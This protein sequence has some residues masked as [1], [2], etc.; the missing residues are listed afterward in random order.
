MSTANR[1]E[2][3][4]GRIRGLVVVGMLIGAM[5][6]AGRQPIVERDDVAITNDVRARLAA[7]THAS[8]LAVT[9]DT[10]AGVVSLSGMVPTDGDRNAVERIARDTPGVRTVDNDVMF[11]TGTPPIVR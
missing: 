10:K 2:Y 5:G 3:G 4:T 8:P 1:N 7:D 9:V 11:G 6:C